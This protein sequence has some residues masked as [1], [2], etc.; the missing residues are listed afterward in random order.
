[1]PLDNPPVNLAERA[2]ETPTTP[3]T[4]DAQMENIELDRGGA[5]VPFM[6]TRAQKQ[7]LHNL[8]YSDE[9]IREM[10]PAEAQDIL[11]GGK[12]AALTA[13]DAEP[14]RAQRAEEPH[15]DDK[16]SL[17]ENLA[18]LD[19]SASTKEGSM[20]KQQD[21]RQTGEDRV[22]RLAA[23]IAEVGHKPARRR[24]TPAEIDAA[25][26]AELRERFKI[27]WPDEYAAMPE[28]TFWDPETEMI[29][30]NDDRGATV[31]VSGKWGSHKTNVTLTWLMDAV[32]DAGARVLYAAGE[33]STGVGKLRIP[34]HCATR[35]ITPEDL[36]GKLATVQAVPLL[37]RE[38]E[39]EQ[40]IAANQEFQPSIIVIDTLATATAGEDE[41]GSRFSSLLRNR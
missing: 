27:V 17:P 31:I 4:G 40:F 36:R 21:L 14:G 13:H 9:H 16:P 32:L 37:T 1:M 18:E 33:G 38:K 19:F 30:R 12:A 15:G 8:G 2:F 23:E 22:S 25:E 39:V 5:G 20:L 35:G 10:K 6:I 11:A 24:M 29:P 26:E 7:E 3:E 41:N 28:P 34:A